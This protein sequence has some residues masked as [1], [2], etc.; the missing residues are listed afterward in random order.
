MSTAAVQALADQQ[1]ALVRAL[2]AG[3]ATPPGFDDEALRAAETALLRKRAGI[4]AR[5]NPMLAHSAGPDFEQRFVAWARGRP[6]TSTHSDITG[7]AEYVGFPLPDRKGGIGA[8]I[9]T[10]LRSK[11]R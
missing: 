7:F 1:A 2:V 5:H 6:K 11:R 8:R 4:L 9:R 3:A 10:F